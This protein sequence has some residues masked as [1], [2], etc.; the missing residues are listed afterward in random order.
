LLYQEPYDWHHPVRQV[1]GD[2]LL[3]AGDAQ[4]A[5]RYFRE[6]LQLFSNN[7]WALTGL[8][9]ALEKQGKSGEAREV[10]ERLKKSFA[11]AD[12]QLKTARF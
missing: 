12:I 10:G 1:L 2:V 11:R 9:R 4:Q 8:K 6:D 5:E 7:G 3:E